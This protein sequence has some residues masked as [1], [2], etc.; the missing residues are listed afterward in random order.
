MLC[1]SARP[2]E[3]GGKV[4]KNQVYNMISISGDAVVVDY[5]SVKPIKALSYDNRRSVTWRRDAAIAEAA[6]AHNH[7]GECFGGYVDREPSVIG[8]LELPPPAMG[9]I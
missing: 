4:Y 9:G 1:Y 2:Q 5:C 6:A 7:H 3:Q 8:N